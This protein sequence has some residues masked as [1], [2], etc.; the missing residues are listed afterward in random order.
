MIKTSISAPVLTG[1]KIVSDED[2]ESFTRYLASAMLPI[3]AARIHMQ[4]LNSNSK[5]IGTYSASYMKYRAKKGYAS[6]GSAV[7]LSLTR[8][9][10]NDWSIIPVSN[11][12]WGLGY[13]NQ[14]NFM[15]SEYLEKGRKAVNVTAHTRKV[16]V[17]GGQVKEVKVKGYAMK[18]WSGYGTIFAHTAEEL[19]ILRELINMYEF[20]KLAFK[21]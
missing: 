13:K 20:D 18:G 3:I 8:A 4:G 10:Q 14:F 19:D 11:N 7:K 12:S 1:A 9:M 17:K 5:P 15:K 16:K 21:V 2:V 6:Q